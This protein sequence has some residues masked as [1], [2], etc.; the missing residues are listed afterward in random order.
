M[1]DFRHNLSPVEVKIFLKTIEEFTDNLLI[2]Y[3]HKVPK[4]CPRCGN[5]KIYQGGAVSY[6]S[7][8]FDKITHE[9]K[10]CLQCGYKEV[11]MVQTIE[12]L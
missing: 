1:N 4:I 9:I 3:C 10:A 5:G 6:F 7:T 2:R 11:A 12:K 8:S